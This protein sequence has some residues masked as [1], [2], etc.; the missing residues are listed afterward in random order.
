MVSYAMLGQRLG[1]LRGSELL[2][3]VV[4]LLVAALVATGVAW[5]LGE[6]LPGSDHAASHLVAGLRVVV[7]GLVDVAVFLVLARAMRLREV[8]D[9]IDVIVRRLPGARAS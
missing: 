6:I 1:G 8:T 9:V 3:F 7:L 5:G 4:R 2:R